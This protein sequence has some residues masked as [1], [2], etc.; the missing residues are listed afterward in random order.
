MALS[1]MP[2]PDG[3]FIQSSPVDMVEDGRV[4]RVPVINGNLVSHFD[5]YLV[6]VLSQAWQTTRGRCSL[7]LGDIK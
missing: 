4:A 5:G 1:W 3:T 6:E 2:R 7:S